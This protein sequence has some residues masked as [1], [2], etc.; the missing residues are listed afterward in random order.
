MKKG[1]IF[2]ETMVVIAFLGTVLLNVYSSFTTVL[3]NAKTRLY[4]DD[5]VYLYRSYYLLAFLEENNLTE[6][7]KAKFGSVG[8]SSS[9]YIAEFGCTGSLSVVQGET[10]VNKSEIAFCTKLKEDWEIAHIFIMPY[11]VDDVVNCATNTNPSDTND[12][13]CQRNVALQNLSVQAVNFLYSLDGFVNADNKMDDLE[14]NYRLVVEFK[15]KDKESSYVWYDYERNSTKNTTNIITYKYYYTSLEIPFGNGRDNLGPIEVAESVA[16]Y[17]VGTKFFVNLADAIDFANSGD[18][19]ILLKNYIDPSNAIFSKNNITFNLNGKTLTLGSYPIRQTNGSTIISNGTITSSLPSTI[20]IIKG[21]MK[22]N[23]SIGN[24]NINNTSNNSSVDSNTQFTVRVGE[25]INTFSK[26]TVLEISGTVNINSGV[27]STTKYTRGIDIRENGYVKF[28]GGKI[29][30]KA[31]SPSGTGGT[32]ILNRGLLDFSGGEINVNTLGINRC[33]IC[34]LGRTNINGGKV[35]VSNTINTNG[36]NIDG[37]AVDSVIGSPSVNGGGCTYID[38]AARF[39]CR[40]TEHCLLANAAKFNFKDAE[41]TVRSKITSSGLLYDAIRPI[42]GGQ[43][44]YSN[45]DKCF[46]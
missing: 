26:E 42:A 15:K 16:N 4:Y 21:N 9:K 3:D 12:V 39:E 43:L 24:L 2:V 1:F 45:T 44:N 8:T 5:P 27:G 34:A 41:S 11:I 32:G 31:D 29:N 13:Y 33:G 19:I 20:E 37:G 7:I 25:N 35:K 30:V 18:T 36:I 38:S 22:F 6:Y 28:L 23:S 10:E 14:K 17:K 40:N 46:N